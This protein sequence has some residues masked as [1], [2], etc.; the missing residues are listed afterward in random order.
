MR[1]RLLEAAA[2]A[3]KAGGETAETREMPKLAAGL[4]VTEPHPCITVYTVLETLKH[5]EFDHYLRAMT[6]QLKPGA[7]RVTILHFRADKPAP[8]WQRTRIKAWLDQHQRGLALAGRNVAIV[9]D[10]GAHPSTRYSMLAAASIPG[11]HQEVE[12]IEEAMTYA[13]K[14]LDLN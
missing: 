5:A 7:P 2:R 3:E 14:R 4:I 8:D 6:R 9:V 12:T 1:E 13:R 10:E 11:G